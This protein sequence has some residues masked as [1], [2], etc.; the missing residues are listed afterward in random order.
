MMKKIMN[1]PSSDKVPNPMLC[2]TCRQGTVVKGKTAYGCSAYKDGCNFRYTFDAIR[3]K[4][5]KQP[6]TA[7]LVTTLL[8]ES[9]SI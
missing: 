8:M 1:T 4:A 3:E 6:L 9:S 2:P 5:N 7:E